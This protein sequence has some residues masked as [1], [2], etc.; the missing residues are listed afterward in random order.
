[1]VPVVRYRPEWAGGEM[2]KRGHGR[3]RIAERDRVEE[4]E[5]EVG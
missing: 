2:V 4:E 3:G 1:M 5:S